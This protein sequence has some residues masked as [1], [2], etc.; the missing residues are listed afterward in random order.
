MACMTAPRRGELYW[1]NLDPAIGSEIAKTRPALII[2]NDI[3]NQYADRVIVAPISSSG[4]G[5]IYPFEVHLNALEG[6]LSKESKVLLDQIRTL[7]KSRLGQHIG[8]L[9]SDRM[10]EVNRAIRISLAV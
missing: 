10:E 9:S 1:T 3:G 8:A 4:L 5:K 2:S 6:G 7:D